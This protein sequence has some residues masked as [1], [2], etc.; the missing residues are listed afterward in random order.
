[1]LCVELARTRSRT[2][3]FPM[4]TTS[5][6]VCTLL[7]QRWEQKTRLESASRD[8]VRNGSSLFDIDGSLLISS[9]SAVTDGHLNSSRLI[10][11]LSA[12]T[13][14]FLLVHHLAHSSPG[15]RV[16]KNLQLRLQNSG[17]LSSRERNPFTGHRKIPSMARCWLPLQQPTSTGR[18][19]SLDCLNETALPQLSLHDWQLLSL[20]LITL[21]RRMSPLESFVP[22]EISM[23]T[24]PIP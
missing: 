8:E 7:G 9:F 18:E 21:N 1:M 23:W 13:L 10:L 15:G 17:V 5:R 6:L 14:N 12:T 24:S 3:R 16:K 20:S 4:G 22:G 2:I 11:G 19:I